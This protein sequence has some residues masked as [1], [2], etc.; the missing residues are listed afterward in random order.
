MARYTTRYAGA[1]DYSFKE[2]ITNP[3]EIKFT[4]SNGAFVKIIHLAKN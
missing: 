4:L 3:F 2:P 1:F